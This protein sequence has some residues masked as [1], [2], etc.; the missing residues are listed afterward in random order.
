MKLIWVRTAQEILIGEVGDRLSVIDLI[1]GARVFQLKNPMILSYA[2]VP[3]PAV[4]HGKKPEM[5]IGFKLLPIPCGE[6]SVKDVSYAG[7]INVQDPV[8]VTYLKIRE[9]ID[10]QKDSPLMVNQ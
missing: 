6:I 7:E 4:I 9:A 5:M 10:A 2:N 8:T 1:S 3:A